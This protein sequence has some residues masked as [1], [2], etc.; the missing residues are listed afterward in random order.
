MLIYVCNWKKEKYCNI[1]S[2][3]MKTENFL[4]HAESSLR[5]EFEI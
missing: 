1:S 5:K 4:S 3:S 2:E